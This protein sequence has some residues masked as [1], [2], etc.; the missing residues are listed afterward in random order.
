M[1]CEEEPTLNQV[2]TV[3]DDG[4]I[5]VDFIGVV[6]VAGLTPTEAAQRIADRLVD[7]R[8]LRSATVTITILEQELG[9]IA[10]SGA[11]SVTGL[12]PFRAGM[13]LSDVISL[14]GPLSTANLAAIRILR[15]SGDMLTVNFNPDSLDNEFNPV[16]VEGDEIFVPM[17]ERTG[18]ISVLGGV[19]SP[20][21]IEMPAGMTLAQAIE[22]AGGLTSRAI[23]DQI[24]LE[25]EGAPTMTLNITTSSG[26]EL[27]S[28]DIIVV[29]VAEQRRYVQ[30]DG[31]VVSPGFV[32]FTPGTTLVQAIERA[33]GLARGARQD[34]ILIQRANQGATE[35]ITVDYNRISRGYMADIELQ[36]GDRV[37][38][39]GGR[40]GI[41]PALQVAAGL[42]LYF[43]LFGR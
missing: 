39:A 10:F 8:I 12:T 36:P 41:N 43:L 40:S 16:L 11:L 5:L 30:I 29:Q 24:R 14:A 6:E 28:G 21:E 23:P 7:D 3:T 25:R 4:L 37:T 33:G 9:S 2:Y 17:T 42:A 35:T 13:R 32:E 31:Q 22:A 1:I 26:Y 15:K 20:G 34:R 18:H 19:E 38:V 27:R